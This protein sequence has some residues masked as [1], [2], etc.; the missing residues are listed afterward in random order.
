VR[1]GI[2]NT[3]AKGGK[4]IT[5]GIDA[6]EIERFKTWHRYS[7]KQLERIYSNQEIAY[8]LEESTKT[9]ER[10]AVRFAAKEAFYKA[11]SSHNNTSAPFF[12]VLSQ[13]E[14][15]KKESYPPILKI[16]WQEL[17]LTKPSSVQLSLTHTNT[18]A[19]ACVLIVW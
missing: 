18:T 16:N 7:H 14:I 17:S 11:L 12:S 3:K 2:R 8:C 6:V 13:C 10:F 1:H 4:M 15:I 5:I 19:L 9:I